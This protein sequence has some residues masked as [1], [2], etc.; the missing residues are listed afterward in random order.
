[1][2]LNSF[3]TSGNSPGDRDSRCHVGILGFGTVGSAVARRLTG[4][5]PIPHLR[6]THICDR[7]ARDKR[8]RQTDPL[9]SLTWTDRFDDLLASD[10]DVIVE[11]V[12]SGEPAVDYVRGTLLAG[13]SVVTSNKLVV[14][15][16]GPALLLLAERQGRQLR[17][18]S[19]VSGAMPLV[20]VLGDGLSGD[21]VLSIDATLNA[22]TSAVLSRMAETE[23]SMDEAIAHACAQGYADADPSTDLDGLDAAAKLAV[24]CALAFGL[25]VTPD[26]IDTRSTSRIGLD[27]LRRAKHRGGTIRQIAHASFDPARGA[28]TAWVA[29]V[30]VPEASLFARMQGP[31]LASVINCAHAGEV[32]ITGA[33]AGGEATAVAV[34]SDI[35]T[36]ARDRAALVPAPV[37]VEPREIKGLSD[38]SFAE[39][40]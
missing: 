24:V 17:F 1:V 27:H 14:A 20:R 12:P 18:G 39:A 22:T 6:L 11:T 30:F 38:H 23:C 36:I 9:A 15:H 32:T 37:L 33:G 7:R 5:D 4:P 21:R 35:R 26:A 13:K 16:H 25:R 2:G 29:P 8:A 40:V 10:V 34:L 28:L 3:Q 31:Q 19:A